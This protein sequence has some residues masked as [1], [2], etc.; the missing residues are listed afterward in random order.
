VHRHDVSD[1]IVKLKSALGCGMCSFIQLLKLGEPLQQ[2][3]TKKM[4]TSVMLK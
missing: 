1:Q 2:K 4:D 3:R